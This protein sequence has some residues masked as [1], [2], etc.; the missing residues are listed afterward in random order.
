MSEIDRLPLRALF[1]LFSGVYLILAMNLPVSIYTTAGHDDALFWLNAYQLVNGNWLGTYSQMTLAKGPGFPLFLAANAVL[2]IPV[3]LSI[4]L[5]YLFACG[6]IANTLREL[7]LNRYLVLIIFVVI[8]FHPA[9][10]PTRII[11]DNIYP[12]LSLI[13]ISGVIRLV[14]APLVQDRRLLSI[15]PYGLVFGFFWVTREEGIWIV[16]GLLILP[17]LKAFQL[18]KQNLPIKDIFYRFA[19]FLLIAT[20]FVSLIALINYHNY[21][22]FEVV[23]FKSKAYSQAVKSLNSVDVGSDLPKVPVSFD[24]RQEIYRVSPSFLQLKDYFEGDRGKM[25]ISPG[26]A[27]FPWTCGDYVSGYFEWAL[28]DAVYLKGYYESPVRAAEFYN[29]ITKEIETACDIG[30]IKCR[31]N[32]VPFMPNITMTQL[33]ELPGKTVEA[34]KFAMVQFPVQA[35][36]GPSWDPMKKL[37]SWWYP[38]DKLQGIRLFLGSPRTTPAPSEQRIKL[39]GWF[40]STNRDWIVL[41][42]SMKG[43]KIKRPVERISSL[44]IAEHFNNPNANFQRFSISLPSIE[45]CSIS[46]DSLSSNNFPIKSLLEKTGHSIGENGTLFVDQILQ[47]NN[48]SA[49]DL[50]LKLKNSLANLYK[51]IIPILV[52][53]G[54]FAYFTNLIFI[55]TGRV[56]ITDV[57]IVSTMMWCLFFSRIVLLV[58]V[59]ISSFS[60]ITMLY[61]SAAFP[62]LCL[63]A[64]LSLQLLFGSKMKPRAFS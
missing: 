14:F 3:T 13:I 44:D 55:L 37:P 24:K 8:L 12:A 18:K 9:L 52:L 19:C 59:D 48:H 41:N 2:G 33:K 58:L 22:K 6:L 34:I 46:T 42:C 62:I 26:C 21:G 7:G 39:S 29:N 35:T 5:F 61:M 36:G 17:F 45:D 32:P 49:Q 54:A 27:I 16:P 28:R 20:L 64:F 30:V 11:R 15:V 38:L 43:T 50:P 1:F 4:A 40:Y 56:A 31:T 60:A 51:L 23:D 57:F 25:W 10:F 63:A 53:L 47:P